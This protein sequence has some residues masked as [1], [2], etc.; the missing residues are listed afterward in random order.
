MV[1][2]HVRD[3]GVGSSSLL[4]PTKPP[5][6]DQAMQTVPSINKEEEEKPLWFAMRVTYR[7][8]M[9]VKAMLETAG[10]CV[11]IPMVKSQQRDPRTGKLHRTDVPAIHNL[12]FVLAT[13]VA[14]QE[15][16]QGKDMLQYIC[17]GTHTEASRKLTIP[18]EQMQ[19][20][21]ALYE[22]DHSEM[23]TDTTLQPGTPVRVISGPFQ[24]MKG[25]FQRINGHR[26][27][28]FVISL[29]GLVSVGSALIRPNMVEEI[30]HEES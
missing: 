2:Y 19:A 30:K 3:V 27:R 25:T 24:G 13:P 21:M 28:Y 16:K 10:F 11:F 20:F 26:N 14:I 7:R 29:E 9:K 5:Q 4:Y 8:E 18:D 1:A 6:A 15:F 22:D 23:V 17:T 12:L